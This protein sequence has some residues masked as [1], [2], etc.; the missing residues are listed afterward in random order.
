MTLLELMYITDNL[1]AYLKEKINFDSK[2]WPIFQRNHFLNEW[3][4][5]MVTFDNRNSHLISQKANTLLCFYMGDIQNYRRFKTIQ[6]DIP[7]YKQYV[8]VVIPDITITEDMDDELQEMLMLANQL[9]AACL[10]VN[11][12]KIVFNT[13]NGNID[14]L[15]NFRHI[16]RNIMCAS[17]FLGCKNSSDYL[18]AARYINKILLL[19]PEKLIIYGKHDIVVDNQLDCLGINYRYYSDFHTRSK[20]YSRTK[21][22]VA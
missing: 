3:P 22:V 15:Y 5:D 21:R 18:S 17:G 16:P 12:V 1:Y 14:T 7:I 10:A 4:E 11:G 6:Q 8:G 2:G 20:N 9:F 19:M 13:R